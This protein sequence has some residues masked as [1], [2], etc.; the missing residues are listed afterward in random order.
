MLETE[1]TVHDFSEQSNQHVNRIQVVRYTGCHKNPV[2]IIVPSF[3]G[4]KYETTVTTVGS[5][6]KFIFHYVHLYNHMRS[7]QRSIWYHMIQYAMTQI[8]MKSG[9]KIFGTRLVD[10]VSHELKQLHLHNTF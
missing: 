8:Y 5:V 6:G 2:N 9:I 7:N 1:G 4:N 10:A 3:S